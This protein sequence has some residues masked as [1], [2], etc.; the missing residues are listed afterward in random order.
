MARVSKV[1]LLPPD[2][3][4]WVD[5]QLFARVTHEEILREAEA[6]GIPLTNGG[7]ARYAVS[8]D[9]TMGRFQLAGE[10][11]TTLRSAIADG[12]DITEAGSRAMGALLLERILS[13]T[14]DEM[15]KADPMDLAEKLSSLIR[16]QAAARKQLG[17]EQEREAKRRAAADAAKRAEQAL[18]RVAEDREMPLALVNKLRGALNMPPKDV[19]RGA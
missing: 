3:K 6:R 11:A 17:E 16:A 14:A 18:E 2:Q 9:A 12:M 1:V 4:R 19:P 8:L 7:L 13:V 10:V 15:A 5:E